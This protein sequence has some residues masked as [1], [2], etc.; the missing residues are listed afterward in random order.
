MIHVLAV[1]IKMRKDSSLGDLVLWDEYFDCN[2]GSQVFNLKKDKKM[3]RIKIQ[4]LKDE[5]L[6]S[7]VQGLECIYCGTEIRFDGLKFGLSC[8]SRH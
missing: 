5:V 6:E 4:T 2:S 3:R 1:E 8:T 7:F